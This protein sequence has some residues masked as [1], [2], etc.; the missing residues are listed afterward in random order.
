MTIEEARA[1]L[2]ERASDYAGEFGDVDISEA[3]RAW[4]GVAKFNPLPGA[5][6]DAIADATCNCVHED[7][8]Q[9]LLVVAR[10]RRG[11]LTRR[12][13]KLRWSGIIGDI[14]AAL[15]GETKRLKEEAQ[16]EDA[17]PK[18]E[19][20]EDALEYAAHCRQQYFAHENDREAQARWG[21]RQ[22]AAHR[23]AERNYKKKRS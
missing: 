19:F 7:L 13:A 15:A 16:A 18:F 21:K 3:A 4:R 22:M 2:A 23:W 8:L 11:R 12:S 14:E 6:H 1:A 20:K 17:L 5:M 9:A 10:E